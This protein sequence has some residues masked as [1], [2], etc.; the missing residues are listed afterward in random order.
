MYRGG[1]EH[2]VVLLLH[3]GMGAGGGPGLREFD[4]LTSG[5]WGLL[6]IQ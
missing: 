5:N 4:D 6:R 2:A 1:R 3:L